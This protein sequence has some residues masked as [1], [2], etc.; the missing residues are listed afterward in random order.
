MINIPCLVTS[1]LLLPQ[2]MASLFPEGRLSVDAATGVPVA[3]EI[4]TSDAAICDMELGSLVAFSGARE[5][6]RAA[7]RRLTCM[8]D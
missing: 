4:S 8:H 2:A 7:L 5:Q 1:A 3:V 6:V